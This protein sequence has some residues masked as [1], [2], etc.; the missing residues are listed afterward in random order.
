MGNYLTNLRQRRGSQ[1]GIKRSL[2]DIENDQ[3]DEFKKELNTPKR[4]KLMSTS[5]Y[6]YKTLFVD[7]KNSDVTIVALNVEWRLH[8]VYLCQAP[9]FSSMFNGSWK[10]ANDDEINIEIA[11]PNITVEALKIVLGSLY[12]DEVIIQPSEVVPILGAAI[13][14][15]LDPLIQQ[16]CD[17][18]KESINVQTV[19]SYIETATQYGLQAI[20][21][22]C[23]DWLLRSLLCHI[24]EYPKT[25]RAI[26]IN[27]MKDLISSPNLFVI[28]TEFS[29]YVVLKMWIFLRENG[30]WN[31]NHADCI[32][33][34]HK[35]FQA[36]ALKSQLAFLDTE[37][38]RQFAPSFQVL[39][40]SHLVH[41]HIDVEMLD[42]DRIIPQEWM[43]PVYKSQWHN[44]LRVDQAVDRGPKEISEEEFNAVCFRCGRVI[45]TDRKHMWR[46]TGYNFGLD[47]VLSYERRCLNLKRN[48]RTN[49]SDHFNATHNHLRRNLMFRFTVASVNDQRQMTFTTTTGLKSVTLA[50]NEEIRILT[51]TDEFTFPLLLSANFIS[52]SPLP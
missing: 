5:Q 8:K 15:Q 39:R 14:F 29:I 22:E 41:H 43:F 18:M 47:L 44:M 49:V 7:G 12:Q 16:C 21:S 48:E 4:K 31:G 24:P 30:E 23:F 13:L 40:L 37:T 34:S 27:L 32:S 35:Y 28:Q 42:I 20:Q 11:D 2:Q 19:I 52:I 9:Y 33:D 46:W 6:I 1:R 25:L 3:E 26:N 38:G 36:E 10:E 50:K 17:I 51:L 45:Y